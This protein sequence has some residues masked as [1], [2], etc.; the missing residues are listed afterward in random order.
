MFGHLGGHQGKKS[1][2]E[3]EVEKQIGIRCRLLSSSSSSSSVVMMV[4]G[5]REKTHFG[6]ECLKRAFGKYG[7]MVTS[8]LESGAKSLGHGKRN[9][10]KMGLT[11]RHICINRFLL[12]L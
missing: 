9:W 1:P 10:N 2:V 3:R 8:P 5:G 7:H 11:V 12:L 4:I 6:E